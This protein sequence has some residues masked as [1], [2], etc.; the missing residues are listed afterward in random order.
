VL[1]MLRIDRARRWRLGS[2][3]HAGRADRGGG[4][5]EPG[6]SVG[7]ARVY[8]DDAG[9]ADLSELRP[10]LLG[11]QPVLAALHLMPRTVPRA[12]RA[13]RGGHDPVPVP[14]MSCSMRREEPAGDPEP[15]PSRASTGGHEPLSLGSHGQ[16][17]RPGRCPATTS[18]GSRGLAL[19]DPSHPLSRAIGSW[20]THFVVGPVRV[21]RHGLSS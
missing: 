20:S 17:R 16:S 10:M 7:S 15:G 19:H 11:R 3:G 12:E 9:A 18:F 1:P 5:R 13:G 2:H 21:R 8:A 6:R 14:Q 4:E